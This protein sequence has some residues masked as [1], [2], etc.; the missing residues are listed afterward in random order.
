[1]KRMLSFFALLII[2]CICIIACKKEETTANMTSSSISEWVLDHCYTEEGILFHRSSIN[3]KLEYYDFKTNTY[4]PLCAKTNCPHNSV[5]CTAIELYQKVAFMGR[6]G[7]KWY[8]FVPFDM[9][10]GGIFHSCDL[11]GENDKQI[12]EFLHEELGINGKCL[13]YDNVCVLAT[14]DVEF[15]EETGTGINTVSGIYRYH[16]DSGEAEVLC[17]EREAMRPTYSIFGKYADQL[18]YTEWD[19]EQYHLKKLDLN[20]KDNKTLLEEKAIWGCEVNGNLLACNV[21]MDGT[22]ELIEVDLE[23]GEQTKVFGPEFARIHLWNK[24]WK[25]FSVYDEEKDYYEMYRY[26]VEEGCVS[27]RKGRTKDEFVPYVVNGERVIG[28]C[29]QLG[30]GYMSKEDFLNGSNDWF[31]IGD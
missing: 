13:F 9:G 7:D 25:F 28:Q 26:T 21:V 6:I 30:L 24:N 2:M 8:Y 19:G 23:T 29:G 27:I 14:C 17:Q 11:D 22:S 3:E 16:L 10:G 5:D 4:M 15:D 18:I 1:M 12:G 20:S 31:I